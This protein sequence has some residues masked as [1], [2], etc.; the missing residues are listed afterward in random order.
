MKVKARRTG[1]RVAALC[2]LVLL[3]LL[4]ISGTAPAPAMAASGTSTVDRILQDPRIEES[5]GLVVSRRTPGVVWTHGDS[6][7]APLLYAVGRNGAT[8]G[9][10]RLT[11]VTGFDWEAVA[12]LTGPDGSRLLAVGDIGDNGAARSRAEI[13]VIPEPATTGSSRVAPVR[14]IRLRYPSGPV[15]AEALLADPR[16]GRLYVVTKGL[17]SSTIYAV[18]TS[19]WPGTAGTGRTVTAALVPVGTVNLTLVTDGAVLPDGRV[20]LRTYGMLA[21]LAPLKPSS[22]SAPGSSSGSSGGST[23]VL[24]PLATTLLPDQKQG[25]GLAVQDAAAG[26][27]LLSSEGVRAP[28][29]R[30]TLPPDVREAGAAEAAASMTASPRPGASG[31]TS[32]PAPAGGSRSMTPGATTGAAGAGA[33]VGQIVDGGAAWLITLVG[34]AAFVMLFLVARVLGRLRGPG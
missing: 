27:L 32:G 24:S 31:A 28:I 13:V 33:A 30:F 6:G 12:A 14:V 2:L 8:T 21:V 17:L 9:T 34:G 11:G 7:S 22:G 19:A 10:A 1:L 25:E 20:V 5:S 16:D 26:V 15:D 3:V 18:P 4:G 29:L 23:S